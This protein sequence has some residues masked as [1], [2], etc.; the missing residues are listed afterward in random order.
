MKILNFGSCNIDYVYS[1]DHI[2]SP[3]ETETT[4]KME[5]FSGGKGLNQSIAVAKAGAKIFH[6]GC[7]GEGGQMLEDMMKSSGVDTTY[8]KKVPEKNGHAIIQVTA[9]GENSIFLYPGS[10]AMVEKD[11][12]DSVLADFSEN[13][14]LLLQNEIS[15]IDYIVEKAYEKGMCIIL[16]PSPFNDEI[17]K[18]DFNMLSYII[19]NEVEA[20][21]VSGSEDAKES[22]AFFQKHYPDLKVMLTLGGRGCIY[23]DTEIEASQ[24]IFPVEVVDTTAAGDTFTGYFIAGIASGDDTKEILKTATMASAI[25]VSREGAAPSIPEKCEV[26]KA[27]SDMEKAND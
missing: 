27:I 8:I 26:L 2:V 20:K 24:E 15:N 7:I 12:I 23:K 21:A 14:I 10:N 6:A 19:L 18:I 16:N 13:D 4:Y 25:A 11:Y 17:K 9:K 22:L 5:T 3:G 1:L